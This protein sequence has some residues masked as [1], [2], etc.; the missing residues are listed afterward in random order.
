MARGEPSLYK[1]KKK[2]KKPCNSATP[3]HVDPV[4][5]INHS[6]QGAIYLSQ[7][8]YINDFWRWRGKPR[9][10]AHRRK[11]SKQNTTLKMTPASVEL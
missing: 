9:G 8:V 6:H 1:K 3:Y 4:L 11:E 5:T 7:F 10:S 2:K